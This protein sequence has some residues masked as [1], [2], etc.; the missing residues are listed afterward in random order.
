MAMRA[1]GHDLAK[2]AAQAR[3]VVD[4][5]A[6]VVLVVLSVGLLALSKAD[7]RLANWLTGHAGDLAVPALGPLAA[8]VAALRER[9]AGL[10]GLLAV[11]EENRR[12]RE[13]N[14]RLLA[15]QAEAARLSVQNGALRE[16]LAVPAAPPLSRI[17]ARVVGDAGS[18]FV[19]TVLV[20]AGEERGVRAGMAATVPEGLAGLVVDVGRRSARILLV[21]DF[22]SRIPVIV[23]RSRDRAILTGDNGPRPRLAFL[24]LEPDLR[25]GDTVLTSG[26]DGLVPAGLV[27]GRIAAVGEGG[28]TLQPAVDW[29]RLDYVSIILFA[30]VP[31]PDAETVEAP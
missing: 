14:R 9:A 26:D 3:L 29:T 20:D 31:A 1:I 17:V 12:L 7:V 30:P 24:P 10:G 23:E 13:E 21:T 11:A 25:V 18:P 4:R 6:L 8:P 16:M 5:A 19:H 22:N 2:A 15:W 27:A 28:A